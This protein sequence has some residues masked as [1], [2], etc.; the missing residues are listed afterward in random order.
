MAPIAVALQVVNVAFTFVVIV[1]VVLVSR[2]FNTGI[3]AR[4]FMYIKIAVVFLSFYV[5]LRGA[6]G[7]SLPGN[8]DALITLLN[9]LYSAFVMAAFA[10]LYRDWKRISLDQPIRPVESSKGT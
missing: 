10:A 1:F 5:L 9:V 8:F 3:F 7:Y 6:L 2:V 4:F